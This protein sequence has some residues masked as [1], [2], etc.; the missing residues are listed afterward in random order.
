VVTLIAILALM[1]LYVPNAS[2]IIL[3]GDEDEDPCGFSIAYFYPSS[4][5]IDAGQSTTLLWQVQVSSGCSV[6]VALSGSPEAAGSVGRIGSKT[7]H[8]VSTTTY[9]LT[10]TLLPQLRTGSATTTVTVNTVHS[11]PTDWELAF[12]HAPIHYQ[13][14]DSTDAVADFLTRVDYDGNLAATDNWENLHTAVADLRG[15]VYYSVVESCT[16]WFV[17]YFMFHPRDWEDFCTVNCSSEHEN[18][19]EGLLAIVRKDG[20]RYGKLEGIVTVAH[21]HFYSYTPTGSP[22]TAGYE[23]IDGVLQMQ[24]DPVDPTIVRP[25][26]FQEAKGH[27]FKALPP[28]WQNFAGG[29]GV[30]YFPGGIGEVPGSGNARNVQYELID[31]FAPNGLWERQKSTARGR[32]SRRGGR[33]RVM[34]AVAVGM[35]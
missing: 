22:L 17:I 30:I 14:T 24:A 19:G 13:D 26:T 12:H 27:A 15:V 11:P 21:E 6:H 34:K 9:R 3:P 16:H 33:C 32:C 4:S 8:P 35:A 23:T 28:S 7:V 25:R 1:G 2:A 5:R 29:D 10:V 20:S 31:L 18:D